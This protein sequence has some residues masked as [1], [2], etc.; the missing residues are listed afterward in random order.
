[1]NYIIDWHSQM[2]LLKWHNVL[3]NDP[4]FKKLDCVKDE[5]INFFNPE[6]FNRSTIIDP[7]NWI[8]HT[9]FNAHYSSIFVVSEVAELLKY[10]QKIQ[11]GN[12]YKLKSNAGK[13]NFRGLEEK[14]F[15]IYVHYLLSSI[16][17]HPKIG[18]V[19]YSSAGNR[20][21]MD[22]LLEIEG[23][24]YNVEITKYYDGFKEELLALST[25]SV[26]VL[27][28]LISKQKLTIDEMFS[29]Y[30]IFKSRD[31]A[32]VRKCKNTFESTVKSLIK[33][34]RTNRSS[35]SYPDKLNTDKHE[36]H[37]ESAFSNNYSLTYDSRVKDYTGS[38]CF[39]ISNNYP[40]L[41]GKV[42]V[43]ALYNEPIEEC[44][45]R[46]MVKIKDKIDQHKDCPHKLIIVIAI[47]QIFSSHQKNRTM[48]IRKENIDTTAIEAM[49]KQRAIVCL[50]FKELKPDKLET[51]F[52]VIGDADGQFYQRF[53]KV[54]LKLQYT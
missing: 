35:I 44:N 31:Q 41:T 9:F 54:N 8:L 28:K 45:S 37:I 39:N 19:Y 50:I 16:G 43:K 7:D 48:A 6:D 12:I 13:V 46:L 29:G 47:E 23:V 42:D 1:M 40:S 3:H 24:K 4:Y 20:K 27:H 17:I 14:F 22:I 32:I 30:F 33:Y 36:F 21:E 11:N 5:L 34:N 53:K 52:L 10:Y 15:E 18:E 51:D 38:I 25:H 49:L 26:E 2:Q